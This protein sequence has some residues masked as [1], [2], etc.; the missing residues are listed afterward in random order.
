MSSFGDRLRRLRREVDQKAEAQAQGDAAAG[1]PGTDRRAAGAP[2]GAVAGVSDRREW[3]RARL[4]AREREGPRAKGGRRQAQERPAP[5]TT[6]HQKI[7]G[8]PAD[9]VED[10]SE[11]GPFVA[12][13]IDLPASH[14]HGHFGLDEVDAV[15]DL[16]WL[17]RDPALAGLDPRTAVYLDIETTGLSGGAGTWP[18]MVA[19]G[20]FEGDRFV[21]WQGFMR[22]PH[23]EEALLAEVARRVRASSGVVSF[24]GKSFDRHRLE[25]KMRLHKIDPGFAERPHLDLYHPLNRLYTRRAGWD[26]VAR[27]AAAPPG[28]GLAN[29]K[30][31][32]MERGLIGLPRKD[33]LSGAHAPEAWFAFLD[34]RPHLLEEVFRHNAL[35]VWSLVALVAHLGRTRSETRADGQ[36][37]G[38]PPLA[39]ALGLAALARDHADREAERAY[40][41]LA[42]ERLAAQPVEGFLGAHSRGRD[43]QVPGRVPAELVLWHADALRLSGAPAAALERYAELETRRALPPRI[44]ARCAAERAKLLENHAKDPAAALEACEVARAACVQGLAS[45]RFRADLDKRAARL[46]AKLARD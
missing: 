20:A 8:M 9:L 46:T 37:L 24:F 25:D 28:A 35:D 38:G 27:G 13:V 11:R 2:H 29:G 7:S 41:E 4:R 22:G 31:G 39:R 15:E 1:T 18:F 32:T 43:E 19:L 21:L 30:L 40:L 26:R 42:Q 6:H 17:A 14:R 44:L 34:Q 5:P 23:E 16:A 45:P 12:R 36:P 3:L 10:Q 33:D